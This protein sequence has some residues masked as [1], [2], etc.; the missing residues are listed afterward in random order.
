MAAT[1]GSQASPSTPSVA[2]GILLALLAFACFT[3]MD[4]VVKLLG[5]RYHVLQVLYLNSVFGLV[6][7]VAIAWAQRKLAT[8]RPN[9]LRLHVLRWCISF[10]G[11]LCVFWSYP[12]MPLAD[13]YAILFT[14][15]LLITA[16]S[17]PIL[18]ETVGWRRWTAIG[19]GFCGVLVMLEPGKGLFQV[20]ALV[21][22][23]GAAGYALN[24]LLVRKMTATENTFSFGVWGNALSVVLVLPLVIPVWQTPSVA[25]L[26]LWAAAGCIAGSAFLILVIAY[27]SA[28]AAVVAPFQYVQLVYGIAV[29][30]A[31]F[32]DLPRPR[33][34]LGA[35]IVVGSGLYI[36][37]R[38][39]QLARRRPLPAETAQ[40]MAAATEKP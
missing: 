26:S 30:L 39:A 12:R 35:A 29:G 24:M 23:L 32:G 5:G 6:T 19:V 9:R 14:A 34:L 25:D 18:G 1:A 40:K 15:P 16:L 10:C 36:I 33:M 31:L 3:A 4:T 28:P 27:R 7:V 38:E 21:T 8:V 37:H 2:S 20:T 17:V 22:L 11:T 13:A